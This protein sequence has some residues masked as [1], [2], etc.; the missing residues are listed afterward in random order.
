MKVTHFFTCRTFKHKGGV[1]PGWNIIIR[2]PKILSAQMVT[3]GT[4]LNRKSLRDKIFKTCLLSQN[5]V[6]LSSDELN[7]RYF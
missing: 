1:E 3:V 7:R 2:V 5:L 6:V 4:T